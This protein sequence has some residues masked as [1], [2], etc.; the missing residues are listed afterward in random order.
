M[1][2]VEPRAI[3]ALFALSPLLGC[4]LMGLDDFGGARCEHDTDCSNSV[5][6]LEPSPSAC[7]TA[8]CQ[9]D[10]GVCVWQEGRE[11]C[12]GIDDDCDG[13]IDEGLA[14][15]AKTSSLAPAAPA[16]PPA[17]A[18]ASLVEPARTF[19]AIAGT[20]ATS[21]LLTLGPGDAEAMNKLQYDSV[22]GKMACPNAQGA[23]V[24]NFTEVALAADAAHLVV[25]S[26]NTLGCRRGQVRVG[27][28]EIDDSP[29]NVWLGK[30]RDEPSEDPTFID[31]GVDLAND[32]C[33]GRTAGISGAT[34]PAVASLGTRANG[35]GALLVWL[36]AD[37]EST[38][39]ASDSISVEALGL[40]VRAQQPTQQAWLSGAD[41]GTP[42]ELGLS[43]SLSAPAV[44][45]LESPSGPGT[46]LVAFAAQ[47]G[48]ELGIRLLTMRVEQARLRVNSPQ[49][50]N[51][52]A[53]EEVV[54]ALGN[55]QR[56]EVGLA[57][58][59][60]AGAGAELCFALIARADLS[61]SEEILSPASI[62]KIAT[63]EARFAPRILYQESGFA[64]DGLTGGWF[65]SW[66][67]AG[68][69][70]D[71]LTLQIARL[72]DKT[73]E[74]LNQGALRS[75]VVAQPL[76]YASSSNGV[77]R[78]GYALIQPGAVLPETFPNWCSDRE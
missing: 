33:T 70:D 78:V 10:R 24:C 73:G 41:G 15:P 65:L 30:A 44:L 6:Q 54:L 23:G 12:N 48:S 50:L 7:G 69:V 21:Q 26:I 56:G 16:A 27:L 61:N 34:R 22:F 32:R 62:H 8:V 77:S 19:A 1:P 3:L 29:F 60:G 75:G 18:E 58:R 9:L 49:F 38:Q 31:N 36:A 67:E 64:D 74:L 46:Y 42:R 72:S 57:W 43:N 71:G 5:S 11:I 35:E 53:A 47:Q 45:A 59:S 17:V 52:G 39:S 40:V 63:P 66:V 37:A 4:S 51:V 20:D 2:S 14:L 55:A 68:S 76:L 25:A 13:L 28:S